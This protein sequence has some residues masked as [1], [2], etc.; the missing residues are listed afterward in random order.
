MPTK[1]YLSNLLA[2][3]SL[4][5]NPAQLIPFKFQKIT[6]VDSSIQG[7]TI[8]SLIH[9]IISYLIMPDLLMIETA[10]ELLSKKQQ[11]RY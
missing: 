6:E 7:F 1:N 4:G 10:N 2:R 5:Y 8:K 11:L 3:I 9:K